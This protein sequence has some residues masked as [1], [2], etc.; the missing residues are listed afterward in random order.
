MQR[1][2]PLMVDLEHLE[3]LLMQTIRSAATA[4]AAVLVQSFRPITAAMVAMAVLMAAEQEAEGQ[5]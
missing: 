5:L 3:H 4:P 1:A 2:E